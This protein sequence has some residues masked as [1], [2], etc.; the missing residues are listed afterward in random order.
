MVFCTFGICASV[1]VEP[2]ASKKNV[3]RYAANLVLSFN[4]ATRKSKEMRFD[5]WAEFS[6]LPERS[7]VGFAASRNDKPHD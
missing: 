6:E 2:V 1:K 3:R 4:V 5:I 7:N